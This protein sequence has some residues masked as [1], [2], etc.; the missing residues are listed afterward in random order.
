MITKV[1]L[2]FKHIKRFIPVLV[3]MLLIFSGCKKDSSKPKSNNGSPSFS[4]KING[5]D[6]IATSTYCAVV[7]DSS[8]HIRAFNVQGHYLNQA[9]SVLFVDTILIEYIEA[10]SIPFSQGVLIDYTEYPSSNYYN[11]LSGGMSITMY[12]TLT[13]K[14]SGTFGAFL[15]GNNPP[16]VLNITNG[17]FN[18]LPYV[19]SHSN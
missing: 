5:T 19:F 18:N 7:V 9:I 13:K 17:Q 12:D 1:S 15:S 10:N 8:L 2:D 6:F 4:A 3:F 11:M 16:G 14:A